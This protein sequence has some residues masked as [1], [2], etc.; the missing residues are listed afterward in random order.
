MCNI[1]L[2]FIFFVVF[3]IWLLQGNSEQREII[4]PYDEDE[5]KI[6]RGLPF[7]ACL[8]FRWCVSTCIGKQCFLSFV[9]SS[10]RR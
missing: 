8:V 3:A 7:C 6:W 1:E 9:L 2:L 10:A 4:E 5:D